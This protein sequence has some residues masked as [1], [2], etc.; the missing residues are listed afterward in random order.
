MMDADSAIETFF[1]ND[2]SDIKNKFGFKKKVNGIVK[3]KKR[4][5]VNEAIPAV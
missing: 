2:K 5:Y 3:S 1:K 4:P